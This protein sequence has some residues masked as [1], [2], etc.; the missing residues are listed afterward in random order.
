M[1][2]WRRH[3][4]RLVT[5]FSEGIAAALHYLDPP[6]LIDGGDEI[7]AYDMGERDHEE[8][9]DLVVGLKGAVVLSGYANPLYEEALRGWPVVTRRGYTFTHDERFECL[10][11]SLA[12]LSRTLHQWTE[13]EAELEALA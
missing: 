11:L 13:P 9:L 7:Y 5:I 12:V 6:Y 1:I 8:L 10:W 4:L 3:D 2:Y